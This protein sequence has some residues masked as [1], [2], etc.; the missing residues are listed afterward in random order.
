MATQR[1]VNIPYG[2]QWID[3]SDI[4]AVVEALRADRITT[5]ERVEQFE[6]KVASY[7]GAKYA[8]AVSSGTAALHCA[9][10]VTGIG[11][12]DEVITTPITFFATVSA[13]AMCG[14]TP[15]LADV[16]DDTINIDPN[17]IADKITKRTK[18]IAPVDFAGH[19]AELDKI[20]SIAQNN[21]LVLVEDA[22]HALGAEYKGRKV[23]S[24]SDMTVFSFHPVKSITT[25]EGGMVLTDNEEY[26]EKM[27]RFRDHNIVR[28]AK[29]WEYEIN[30]VGYNYRLSDVACALGI[31]QMDKLDSFIARRREIARM[32]NEAFADVEEIITPIELPLRKSAYHLYII[33]LRK[34]DRDR[35]MESL[36]AKG[37]YAQAHY[38]PIHFLSY[39][40]KNKGYKQGDFPNAEKYYERC[41]SLPIFPRMTNN[42]V[43][44]VV[45][46]V[47]SIVR[48]K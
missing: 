26:Y 23:G 37:I 24:I 10:Y 22:C 43:E 12:G 25:G 31:S 13:I 38:I 4:Q 33:Q 16:R 15:I 21:R 1:M 11:K 27:R 29:H 44:Y 19:P 48:S 9:Y 46:T 2:H 5:G 30:D 3:E 14:G 35:F 45:D 40:R 20:R 41:L 42:D 8:I 7:C 17:K 32:Y 6:K 36:M 34:I 28:G 47:K 39:M 18:A